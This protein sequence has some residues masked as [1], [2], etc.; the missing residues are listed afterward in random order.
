MNHVFHAPRFKWS[1]NLQSHH[2]ISSS[3]QSIITAKTNTLLPNPLTR[4]HRNLFIVLLR[5]F[6]S[7]QPHL[8]ITL[9]PHTYN[10]YSHI[11][12]QQ[13]ISVHRPPEI[14]TNTH[15]HKCV[16]VA[17]ARREPKN[18]ANKL[19]ALRRILAVFSQKR[20]FFLFSCGPA[21]N[22]SILGYEAP[23]KDRAHDR[24]KRIQE[25]Y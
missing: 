11:Q 12:F 22:G 21:R 24:P 16:L 3:P 19:H 7:R 6:C 13:L 10:Y 15:T 1:L 5:P 23:S 20:F 25:K 17:Q 9:K 8:K 2:I 18:A 14:D 4:M